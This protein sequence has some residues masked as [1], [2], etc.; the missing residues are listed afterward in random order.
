M[1]GDYVERSLTSADDGCPYQFTVKGLENGRTY[2]FMLRAEDAVGFQ[3]ENLV[4]LAAAP[5]PH[6]PPANSGIAIDGVFDD[7]AAV[8]GHADAEGEAPQLAL[9]WVEARFAEDASYHYVFYELA[10]P[11]DAAGG[12]QIFIN[13]DG[14]SWTGLQTRGGADF[15]VRGAQLLRYGGT[16]LDERWTAV[17]PL[18]LARD[19]GRV[20]LRVSR[21]TLAASGEGP[22]F[23]FV[24]VRSN[25][26]TD[27]MPEGGAGFHLP[28]GRP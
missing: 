12:Q 27:V 14:R 6:E 7:W 11:L 1:G 9:D 18:E 22:V 21:E 2:Y 23:S 3:D 28:T 24:G 26:V 19:G 15:V 17:G 16:G 8:P 25:G 4:V 13:A 20:E 10:Q 5:R